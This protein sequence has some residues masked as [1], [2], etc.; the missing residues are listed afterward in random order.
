MTG[1]S[2][3]GG[4]LQEPGGTENGNLYGGRYFADVIR[5]SRGPPHQ[6]SQGR[7]EIEGR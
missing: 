6:A 2:N 3:D 7:L 4:R 1:L 5:T